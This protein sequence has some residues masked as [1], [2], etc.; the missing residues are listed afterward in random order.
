MTE[1]AATSASNAGQGAWRAVV[2]QRTFSWVRQLLIAAG[3][4][5]YYTN[6]HSGDLVVRFEAVTLVLVGVWANHVARVSSPQPDAGE[7]PER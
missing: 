5:W 6:R 3:V 4:Y 1:P 7:R 2:S